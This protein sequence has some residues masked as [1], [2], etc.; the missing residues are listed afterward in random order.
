VKVFLLNYRNSHLAAVK[1]FRQKKSSPEEGSS[2][3]KGKKGRK[4]KGKKEKGLLQDVDP[5]IPGPSPAHKEEGVIRRR[6]SFSNT[7]ITG[8]GSNFVMVVPDLNSN[9]LV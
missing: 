7:S 1:L 6:G 9:R 8:R 5:A 4:N 2:S 3:K